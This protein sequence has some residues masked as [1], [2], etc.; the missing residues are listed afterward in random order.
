M[1]VVEVTV[2]WQATNRERVACWMTREPREDR[3]WVHVLCP[4]SWDGTRAQH[5][6]RAEDVWLCCIVELY[7]NLQCRVMGE[8]TR[9]GDG[10]KKVGV[11][12]FKQ[13]ASMVVLG[14]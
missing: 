10:E 13:S 6:G 5:E 14:R 4:F 3:E 9:L 2:R 12:T 7:M 8:R 1:Y 11:Q